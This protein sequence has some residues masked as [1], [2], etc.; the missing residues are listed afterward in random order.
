M[1]LSFFYHGLWS[2][3]VLEP[4]TNCAD[5]PSQ[6]WKT[7]ALFLFSIGREFYWLS[8][9]AIYFQRAVQGFIKQQPVPENFFVSFLLVRNIEVILL[10]DTG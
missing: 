3:I 8:T 7:K 9:L 4:F 10:D 6:E 5:C 2:P 1:S